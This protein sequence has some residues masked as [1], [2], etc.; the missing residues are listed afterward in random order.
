MPIK[1]KKYKKRKKTPPQ[2]GKPDSCNACIHNE[3]CGL[4]PTCP[5]FKSE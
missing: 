1:K 5:H 4:T 3:V 2:S